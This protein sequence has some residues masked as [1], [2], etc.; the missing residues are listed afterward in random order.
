MDTQEHILVVGFS[1]GLSRRE[2]VK[3]ASFDDGETRRSLDDLGALSRGEVKCCPGES[4][5]LDE[6]RMVCR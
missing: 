5:S 2:R 6:S 4:G 1:R 3:N